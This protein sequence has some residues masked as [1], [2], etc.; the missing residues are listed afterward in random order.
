YAEPINNLEHLENRIQE[1]CVTIRMKPGV[2]ERRDSFSRRCR[3]CIDMEGGHFEHL[4]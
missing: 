3:V 2:F 4:L 1:A